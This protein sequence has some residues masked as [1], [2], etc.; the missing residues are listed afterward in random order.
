MPLGSHG[1]GAGV[2]GPNL[3]FVGGSTLPGGGDLTDRLL[4]FT[5]P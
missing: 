1:F 5:L 3:Y 2:I 4:M